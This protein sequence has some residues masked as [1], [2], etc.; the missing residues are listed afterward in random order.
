[1]KVKKRRL[2]PFSFSRPEGHTEHCFVCVCDAK[3]IFRFVCLFVY[4]VDALS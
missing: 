2:F 3:A 1:M 4:G